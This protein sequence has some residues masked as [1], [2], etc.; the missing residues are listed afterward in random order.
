MFLS[1]AFLLLLSTSA[2]SAGNLRHAKRDL[3]T[4]IIGGDEAVEDR[5]AYAVS[6][7]DSYGHFCGGSLIAEDVVL[8]AA[9]CDSHG[10]G[11]YYAVV[12]RHAHEDTDGQELRV[13]KALPHPDY[14]GDT[15]DNDFMLIF[16][17]ESANSNVFVKLNSDA[18]TPEIGAAVTVM[19]WGDIDPSDEQELSSELMEVE[20]NVI[21][22]EECELSDGEFGSY[23]DQITSNMLCAREEGGGEDS[24]QGDSGGGLV[25]KG[26]DPSGADDLQVGVVSW[27]IGCASEDYP[28]VYARLSAQYDWIKSEVCKGSKN[29][30]SSFGCEDTES[31]T[32]QNDATISTATT[33]GGWSIIVTE[34]FRSG[35]GIFTAD[36]KSNRAIRYNRAK[37][38]AGVIRMSAGGTSIL[39]SSQISVTNSPNKI[40]VS[41][42]LYAVNMSHED[43]MCIDYQ[44]STTLGEHCWK[45]IHDFPLSQWETKTFEFDAEDDTESLRLRLRVDATS[46]SGDILISR[47]NI[48]GSA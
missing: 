46:E 25:I 6:L 9:H 28:G 31:S 27:G 17:N 2:V 19:G 4:R 32:T 18:A 16:L 38:E 45:A 23:E 10:K 42:D 35:Y 24:C 44:T 13:K 36:S 3:R 20:V 40:K 47:V 21:T 48:E 29:P 22:N 30:P 14:D 39:K 34:D 43:N 15:T 26:A 7:S 11:N 1:K 41:M 37:G 33:D 12:G 5:Y 8:S